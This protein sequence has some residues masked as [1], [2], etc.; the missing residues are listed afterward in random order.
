MHM[1]LG[2]NHF[3]ISF[4]VPRKNLP[5][6][7]WGPCSAAGMGTRVRISLGGIRDS[8]AQ[9]AFRQ[10]EL[11]GSILEKRASLYSHRQTGQL[12][13]VGPPPF[14]RPSQTKQNKSLRRHSSTVGPRDC[15]QGEGD[16]MRLRKLGHRSHDAKHAAAMGPPVCRSLAPE[17]AISGGAPGTPT[18]E[19]RIA[20]VC[21]RPTCS[22]TW[23]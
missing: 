20:K 11:P 13:T 16:C 5:H 19:Y 3:K 12:S 7:E 14:T 21:D 23:D 2:H 10:W 22:G 4:A 1:S 9:A 6:M 8:Q 17:I 18:T 15:T